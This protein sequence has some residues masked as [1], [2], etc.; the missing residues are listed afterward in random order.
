MT[1]RLKKSGDQKQSDA[2]TS[3]HLELI[4]HK[5]GKS[6]KIIDLRDLAIFYIMFECALK[7]AELRELNF[8]QIS[9]QNNIVTISLDENVYPLSEQASNSVIKW[10]SHIKD[11]YSPVFRAVDKHHNV[12]DKKLNDSSIFRIFRKAAELIGKPELRFSG[13]SARIGAAQDLHKRGEK[14]TD[15]QIFGRWNSPVMPFQYIGNSS[16]SKQHQLRYKKFKPWD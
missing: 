16:Q 11:N 15:I 5:L 3:L 8:E 2:F 4:E 9:I 14:I 7:R 1:L 12:S 10:L 6:D 13:Q